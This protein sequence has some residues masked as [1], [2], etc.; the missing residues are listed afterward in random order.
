M[1]WISNENLGL[2][3]PVIST[4]ANYYGD[5]TKP[6]GNFESA[7]SGDETIEKTD[8]EIAND[9]LARQ[10]KMKTIAGI[11][12]IVGL[13]AITIVLIKTVK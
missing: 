1:S 8:Q 3:T 7:Q 12:G 9:L 2:P 11:A 4:G 6:I 5:S 13:I 10:K